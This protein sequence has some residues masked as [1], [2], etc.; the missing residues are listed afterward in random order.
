MPSTKTARIHDLSPPQLKPMALELFVDVPEYG[1]SF[2]LGTIKGHVNHYDAGNVHPYTGFLYVGDRRIDAVMGAVKW[3]LPAPNSGGCNP[4]I[5]R[6]I[7]LFLTR[8]HYEARGT[9][10]EKDSVDVAVMKC[11]LRQRA[12]S[13]KAVSQYATTRADYVE[14]EISLKKLPPKPKETHSGIGDVSHVSHAVK[15]AEKHLHARTLAILAYGGETGSEDACMLVLERGAWI[16]LLGNHTHRCIVRGPFWAW[17]YG[18]EKAEHFSNGSVEIPLKTA[19]PDA[20][21]TLAK[22]SI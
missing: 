17:R 15:K 8:K 1:I 3:T 22:Q 14:R 13:L 5:E 10:D 4:K 2:E 20:W 11:W 7:A 18:D 6:N 19:V 16:E 9:E 12:L 21:L